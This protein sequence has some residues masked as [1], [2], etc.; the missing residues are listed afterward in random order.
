[1]TTICI[2]PSCD[3]EAEHAERFLRGF[4]FQRPASPSLF[5]GVRGRGILGRSWYQ[6]PSLSPGPTRQACPLTSGGQGCQDGTD[7]RG[8]AAERYDKGEKRVHRKGPTYAS[9]S[10][11]ERRASVKLPYLPEGGA[12]PKT[13]LTYLPSRFTIN[14]TV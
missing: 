14:G 1:M 10:M 2:S 11:C 12:Q 5:T 7:A 9:P 4:P 8:D 13:T 6:A 3:R